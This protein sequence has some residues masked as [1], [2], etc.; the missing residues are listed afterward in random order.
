MKLSDQLK[1]RIRAEEVF[2]EQIRTELRS[3]SAPKNI[4][5]KITTWLNKPLCIWFLSAVLATG[6]S[7]AYKNY[8]SAQAEERADMELEKVAES[9][10][11]ELVR[12]LDGEIAM[13]PLN[14]VRDSTLGLRTSL[15]D[16][17]LLKDLTS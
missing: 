11:L 17:N 14:R 3:N 1:D 15:I 7:E 5:N 9:T 12:K 13:R 8:Q 16:A 2:R 6:I 4:K 10:K